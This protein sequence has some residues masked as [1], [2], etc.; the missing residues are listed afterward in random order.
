MSNVSSIVD[1][2]LL[3]LEERVQI[4]GLEKVPDDNL[5]G[6]Y[7]EVVSLLRWLRGFG[8]WRST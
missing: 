3:A 6:F 8:S 1:G 7:V 2:A 4:T 5:C